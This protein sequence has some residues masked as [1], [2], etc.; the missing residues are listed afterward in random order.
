VF[1]CS[2]C[3]AAA[4]FINTCRSS[5]N[6]S[7]TVSKT[8]ICWQILLEVTDTRLHGN[9]LG[10]SEVFTNRYIQTADEVTR[11][12]STTFCYERIMNV[13]F[14]QLYSNI[15]NKRTYSVNTA[16]TYIHAYIYVC[17]CVCVRARAR[18]CVRARA[19]ERERDCKV[20]AESVWYVPCSVHYLDA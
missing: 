14:K 6:M 1:C 5:R 15:W 9:L 7:C 17:V 2:K 12:I 3:A 16:Q 19:W 20:N 8:L 4:V 13:V 10:V 11:C 18:A